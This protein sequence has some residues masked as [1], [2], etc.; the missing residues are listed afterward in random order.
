MKYYFE[1]GKKNKLRTEIDTYISKYQFNNSKNF[2]NRFD[3]K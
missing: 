1:T 2:F 3:S